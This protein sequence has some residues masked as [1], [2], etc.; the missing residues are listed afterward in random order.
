LDLGAQNDGM[1][2]KGMLKHKFLQDSFYLQLKVYA[3]MIN[4][5]LIT[6]YD[7]EIFALPDDSADKYTLTAFNYMFT[8]YWILAGH[9]MEG[10]YGYLVKML[11]K[12]DKL[13]LATINV[14]QAEHL[15]FM[16]LHHRPVEEIAS[17]YKRVRLIFTAAKK[18][19]SIQRIHY[20]YEALLSEEKK[21]DIMTLIMKKEPKKWK[22]CEINKFRKRLEDIAAS[23]PLAGEAVMNMDLIEYCCQLYGTNS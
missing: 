10:A 7:P 5:K 12:A 22:D 14:L 21:K 11:E 17:L 2:V 8:Y 16:V 18:D 13:P 4:G 3:E 19:I 15:F 9:D 1:N 23:Y 6:E 20:I